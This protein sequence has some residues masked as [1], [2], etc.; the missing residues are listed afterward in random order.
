MKKTGLFLILLVC[1]LFQVHA[2]AGEQ[3]EIDF[4][5]FLPNSSDQ[6]ANENRAIAQLNNLAK[7]LSGRTLHL[8]QIIIYGYAADAVNDIDPVNL[9]RNRA[10]F[11]MNELQRRGI[12]RD[13]FSEPKGYGAVDIWGQNINEESRVPNRRVRVLLDGEDLAPAVLKA[14]EPSSLASEAASKKP[15]DSK[16][17]WWHLLWLL[18]PLLL[19]FYLLSRRRKNAAAESAPL[20]HSYDKGAPIAAPLATS[21]KL[22]NLEEE[23]R[24]RAYML[25]LE[26]NGQNGDMNGD[27]Y[28]ALPEICAKYVADGY[29]VYTENGTWWARKYI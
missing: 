15:K 21:A 10:N 5:L 14:D 26:R 4:L 27:W 19:L 3:E 9:S 18:L 23:I 6:F 24:Y 1:F 22:V 11:V 20:P 8:G 12:Q 16:F 13:L 2:E 17:P 25:N 28:K 29:E 7:I